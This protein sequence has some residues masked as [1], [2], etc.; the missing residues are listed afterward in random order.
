MPKSEN[1]YVEFVMRRS[2]GGFFRKQVI[3][4]FKPEANAD[5]I[6]KKIFWEKEL[7]DRKLH[8]YMIRKF[9]EQTEA[10]EAEID[11]DADNEEQ[12]KEGED[13]DADAGQQANA[14]EILLE[15]ELGDRKLNKDSLVN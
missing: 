2:L 11:D 13:A 3:Y 7:G 15:K 5:E 1:I 12:H 14:D 6:L 9:I 4:R 8:P 10:A